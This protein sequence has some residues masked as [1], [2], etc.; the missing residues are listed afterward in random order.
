MSRS[1]E[2]LLVLAA[3]VLVCWVRTRPLALHGTEVIAERSARHQVAARLVQETAGAQRSPRALAADVERWID[4]H[5]AEFARQR[6]QISARLQDEWR[7]QEPDGGAYVYL[8]DFDSYTWLRMARNY[9]R[10]GTT[11]DALEN[12]ECRATYSVAPL[13][14][15]LHARSLHVAAIIALHSIVQLVSPMYPLTATAFWVPVIVGTL[16]VLPAFFIGR[17]LG[18]PL[19]G[20]AAALLVSLHPALL[21]RSIG[22]DNDVWNVVLPLFMVWAITEALSATRPRPQVA[23]ALGT[24]AFAALHGATWSGWAFTY[25]VVLA[26]LVVHLLLQLIGH[27]VKAMRPARFGPR[28]SRAQMAGSSGGTVWAA[29]AIRTG[30]R[31]AVTFYIAT[32]VLVWMAAPER[33][34]LTL[35]LILLRAT[36][37]PIDTTADTTFDQG[38]WPDVFSTVSEVQPTDLR[39]IIAGAYGPLFCGAALLGALLLM[40]PRGRWRRAHVALCIGGSVLYALLVTRGGLD[41][42]ATLCLAGIPLLAAAVLELLDAPCETATERGSEVLAVMWFLAGFYVAFR[43]GRFLLLLGPGLGIAIAAA[44]GRVYERAT[45]LA[46]RLIPQYRRAAGALLFVSLAGCL[47]VPVHK[48]YA[49]AN[50]YLPEMNDAWWDTLSAI[51][52]RSA[53][54]AIVNTWWDYGYW[55]E[56]VAERRTTVDGSLLRTHLPYW[57]G[58]VLVSGHERESVGLLRMLNCG[59]EAT[60]LPEGRL[61]AYQKVLRTAGD[62]TAAHAIVIELARL[63]RP[64][65][66][67]HLAERGF[68]QQAVEDVLASTHCTP[69]ETYLLLSSRLAEKDT[70]MRLGLW[71]M[72]RAYIAQAASRTPRS[73]AVADLTR[74]F[75]Y[76]A[77]EAAA[78]YARARA[79]SRSDFAIGPAPRAPSDAYPCGPAREPGTLRC[80]LGLLDTASNR[81]VEEFIFNVAVPQRSRL[82]YRPTTPGR[83]SGSPVEIAPGALLIAETERVDVDLPQPRY[84]EV[85]VL[86]D[87]R[88]WRIRVG[89]PALIRSTFAQL[90]YL[91]GRYAS[92]YTKVDERASDLNERVLAFKVKYEDG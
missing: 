43:G 77:A 18:G 2:W 34:Y 55:V 14:R 78:L 63:G 74:R 58:R 7:Y 39:S 65:A 24:A 42:T 85:G 61:G 81:I 20:V 60:P 10:T 66:A 16:G 44:F 50:S 72:R 12:G 32:G 83:P 19:A 62:A 40:L 41:A 52:E 29:P 80:P 36:A 46:R 3:A 91:D 48:G 30:A 45:R 23:W 5:P 25:A 8:G 35:P 73:E 86:L 4:Q 56:Y 38:V 84:G 68:T 1:L 69:P 33:P 28:N 89:P 76:T 37:S 49:A 15:Q 27:G 51:R 6:A 21:Q 54:D 11:C 13:G 47:I 57:I 82:R 22:S 17:R 9:L 92:H 67:A 71:D 64:A 70:W 87:T 26:A 75:G 53:P 59:S 31:V 79:T 88:T 90:L